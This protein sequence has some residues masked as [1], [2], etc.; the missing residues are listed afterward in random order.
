MNNVP[1]DLILSSPEEAAEKLACYA[2]I[3]RRSGGLVKDAG[4][5]EWWSKSVQP[6]ISDYWGK[7]KNALSGGSGQ[8]AQLATL[9]GTG[10]A[11]FGTLGL[12]RE[13]TREKKRR[14]VMNAFYPAMMGG[15][16]G[17]GGGLAWQNLPGLRKGVSDIFSPQP[18]SGGG[19]PFNEVTETLNNLPVT[20][21]P[22]RVQNAL[23]TKGPLEA[24]N[25]A[26]DP[27]QLTA[28]GL[29]PVGPHAG[30]A[31]GAGMTGAMLLGP[32]ALR[33]LAATDWAAGVGN[34]TGRLLSGNQQARLQEWLN[35]NVKSHTGTTRLGR[36]AL[37]HGL[38]WHPRNGWQLGADR[39]AWPG[40]PATRLDYAAS[41]P[42]GSPSTVI[43]TTMKDWAARAGLPVSPASPSRATTMG[44]N[45]SNLG[46]LSPQQLRLMRTAGRQ[47]VQHRGSGRY[48]KLKGLAAI[49]PT[50]L[51][52]W[53]DSGRS[54]PKK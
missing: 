50:L 37:R 36:Q 7:Y 45:V 42:S 49:L 31:V 12:I 18:P 46:Q 30:K 4:V 53:A 15:L 14:N 6:V 48:G 13:M 20:S 41:R 16:A 21:L 1:N 34:A 39:A 35:T 38:E 54:A 11:A 24:L 5:G 3:S 22:R 51:G 17:L 23:N 26:L 28:G 10:A 9:A 19:K 32:K 29:D 47:G 43:S 52:W 44:R 8:G 33:G 27:G 25:T 40:N 2:L